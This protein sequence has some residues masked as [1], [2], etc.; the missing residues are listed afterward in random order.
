MGDIMKAHI[1]FIF[2]L[3]LN[4]V[5]F[6]VSYILSFLFNG[7]Y[8]IDSSFNGQV[9]PSI[10]YT[11]GIKIFVFTLFMYYQSK[12]YDY[13]RASLGTIAGNILSLIY[14]I[15]MGNRIST[16]G[17]YGLN[18]T[19]DLVFVLIIIA[20]FNMISGKSN[21]GEEVEDINKYMEMKR[22][23][24]T[25][26]CSINEKKEELVHFEFLMEEKEREL[27]K[28][29]EQINAIDHLLLNNDNRLITSNGQL[30]SCPIED[31]SKCYAALSLENKDELS[32]QL[33]YISDD[34]AL[35]SAIIALEKRE[36]QFN[37]RAKQIEKK[38]Q[39]IE[40]A[41]SNLEQISKTIKDRMQLLEDKKIYINNKIKMLEE[42][43]KQFNSYVN[44]Q[45]Y[46]TIFKAPDIAEDEV[47]LK[48]QTKEI[49]INKNDLMEIRNMIESVVE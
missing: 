34:D 37:S 26:I 19:I 35:K 38:E 3:V 21:S 23:L 17:M 1:K 9:S 44:N 30:D 12:R 2:L 11:I 28:I 40:K 25:I 33:K 47:K 10:Y 16:Y 42:K 15:Y 46:E 20:L 7:L 13:I 48:D 4:S 14:L 32:G 49:I 45:L 27:S 24:E 8:G 31:K 36:E 5:L 41:V 39:I 43:E 22:D 6:Y 18:A 29:E